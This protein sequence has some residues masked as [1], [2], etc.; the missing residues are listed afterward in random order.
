MA[1]IDAAEE[2]RMR[3]T[4]RINQRIRGNI[5]NNA[6]P[7]CSNFSLSNTFSSSL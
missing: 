1:E 2:R 5:L 4:D 7:T 6:S 3:K